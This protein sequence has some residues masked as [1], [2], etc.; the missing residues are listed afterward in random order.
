MKDLK[1]LLIE[2]GYETREEREERIAKEI[3][4]KEAKEK[5]MKQ[6]RAA[7][8]KIYE[9]QTG[10]KV[11]KGHQRNNTLTDIPAD[12][13]VKVTFLIDAVAKDRYV[14]NVK[15]VGAHNI[16]VEYNGQVYYIDHA[17]IRSDQ[18]P[19]M[20]KIEKEHIGQTRT[21]TAKI[22]TYQRHD[23]IKYEFVTK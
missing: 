11:C 21:M 7:V 15:V 14:K 1:Q 9:E 10:K 13:P 3:R 20:K 19:S 4:N 8:D 5:R 18:V 17:W 23:K 6:R 2:A 22:K 12:V 16:Q